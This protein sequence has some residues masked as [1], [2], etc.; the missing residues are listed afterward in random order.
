[1]YLQFAS[2]IW[3]FI[4]HYKIQNLFTKRAI[5]QSQND[6]FQMAYGNIA[7]TTDYV[8]AVD[9]AWYVNRTTKEASSV[10]VLSA[11]TTFTSICLT[12]LP[13]AGDFSNLKEFKEKG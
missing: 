6:I 13:G 2:T 4:E 9:A 1:M 5:W 10:I 11:A 3:N 7:F 12:V 8:S